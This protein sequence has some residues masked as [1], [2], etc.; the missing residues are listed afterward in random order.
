M[1]QEEEEEPA[2]LEEEDEEE[3]GNEGYPKEDG[4]QEPG[5]DATG[6][7]VKWQQSGSGQSPGQGTWGGNN[8]FGSGFGDSFGGGQPTYRGRRGSGNRAMGPKKARPAYKG[9]K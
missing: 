8:G 6:R 4:E 7:Q 3:G 9:R 2:A 1:N 5:E